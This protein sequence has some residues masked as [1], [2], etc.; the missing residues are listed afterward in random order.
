M[1]RSIAALAAFLIVTG[2]LG[3]TALAHARLAKATPSAGQTLATSPAAIALTFTEDLAAGST[4][5]VADA[6]GATVSIGATISAADRTQMSI[7]LKPSLPNGVYKVSWH[8]ISADDGDSLD[9]TF[10]FGVGVPA[11]STATLPM[12]TNG[13]AIALLVIAAALGLVSIRALHHGKAPA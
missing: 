2:V 1:T 10:F 13:S 5:S 12:S 7:A 11:P 9:G 8:S 3:G 6:N 4:G